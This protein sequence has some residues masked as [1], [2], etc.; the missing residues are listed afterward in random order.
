MLL[1]QPGLSTSTHY[2]RKVVFTLSFF[3]KCPVEWDLLEGSLAFDRQLCSRLSSF[4]SCWSVLF[5][6]RYGAFRR[7]WIGMGPQLLSWVS[8]SLVLFLRFFKFLLFHFCMFQGKSFLEHSQ[9]PISIHLFSLPILPPFLFKK[10]FH[11]S[12]QLKA[13]GPEASGQWMIGLASCFLPPHLHAMTSKAWADYCMIFKSLWMS[14][15]QPMIYVG[16]RR[17]ILL[18]TLHFW[19]KT[20]F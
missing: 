5:G 2:G 4:G 7:G 9:T 19:G 1:L 16:R 8:F 11:E 12:G 20:V 15:C 17:W 10:T 13:W 18:H 6:F 14:I 3:K